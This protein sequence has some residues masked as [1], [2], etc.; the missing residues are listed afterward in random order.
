[1]PK[2]KNKKYYRNTS[3]PSNATNVATSS[4]T[5]AA[6]TPANVAKAPTPMRAFSPAKVTTM[7]KSPTVGAELKVI[8]I[9]TVA[10]LAAIIVLSILLR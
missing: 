8:G 2:S 5:A 6:R 1:M 9:L 10:I 7:V 3:R 4:S